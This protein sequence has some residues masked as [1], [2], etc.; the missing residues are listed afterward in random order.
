MSLSS[1]IIIWCRNREHV[2]FISHQS[3]KIWYC[4]WGSAGVEVRMPSIYESAVIF[5]AMDG[6][7]LVDEHY[8]LQHNSYMC[9]LSTWNL[10]S[11]IWGVLCRCK[12]HNTLWKLNKKKKELKIFHFYIFTICTCQTD[13]NEVFQPNTSKI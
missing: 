8:A 3:M 5:Q 4:R 1:S 6:A 10:A 7:D 11:V 13:V 12:T 2:V 9:L